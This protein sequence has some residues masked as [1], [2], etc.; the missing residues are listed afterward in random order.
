M[1]LDNAPP[2]DNDD[3]GSDW[4]QE[5]QSPKDVAEIPTCSTG[6]AISSSFC[7]QTQ[8]TDSVA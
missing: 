7:T 6:V 3:A 8:S 2:Q 1:T 4:V 5:E